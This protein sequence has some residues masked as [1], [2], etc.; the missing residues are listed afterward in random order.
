MSDYIKR[1][2]L[3]NALNAQRIIY[4]AAVNETIIKLPPADVR[5]NVKAHWEHV[6]GD[7][8]R[9]SGCGNVVH[10]EGS[11]ENPLNVGGYFCHNCG[12]DMRG[13]NE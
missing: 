9:C 10:T 7:E 1:K 12:A 4:N 6:G 11:W 8:W 2:D 13:E 3:L 5:K